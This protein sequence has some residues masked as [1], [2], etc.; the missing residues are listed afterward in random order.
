MVDLGMDN[1][2][3]FLSAQ[4]NMQFPYMSQSEPRMVTDPRVGSLH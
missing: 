1:F 3:A 4:K 2:R